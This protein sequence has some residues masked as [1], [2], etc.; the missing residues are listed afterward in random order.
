[1]KNIKTRI[2]IHFMNNYLLSTHMLLEILL[3]NE[4]KNMKSSYI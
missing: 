3:I 4:H 1:M 2:E